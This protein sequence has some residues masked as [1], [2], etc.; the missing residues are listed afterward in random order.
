MS[1][2]RKLSDAFEKSI[3]GELLPQHVDAVRSLEAEVEALRAERDALAG[4]LALAVASAEKVRE[5]ALIELRDAIMERGPHAYEV[6]WDAC[7]ALLGEEE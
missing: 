6:A 5:T 3:G 4:Q 1:D 2:T 7:A